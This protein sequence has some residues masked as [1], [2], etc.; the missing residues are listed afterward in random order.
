MILWAKENISGKGIPRV[1]Q[2]GATAREIAGNHA[3]NRL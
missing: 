2:V 1:Q 3:N